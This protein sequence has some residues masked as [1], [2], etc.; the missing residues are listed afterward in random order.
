MA[1]EYSVTS[2]ARARGG[3]S[4]LVVVGL[5]EVNKR[6]LEFALTVAA[7]LAMVMVAA[8]I[9]ITVHLC[10]PLCSKSSHVALR[11][12]SFY[13][14]KCA[15]PPDDALTVFIATPSALGAPAVVL[16]TLIACMSC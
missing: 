8:Q 14:R 10:T 3:H 13:S 2:L 5:F 6:A 9:L 16:V 11:R 12:R 7:S 4:R 15:A 1:T